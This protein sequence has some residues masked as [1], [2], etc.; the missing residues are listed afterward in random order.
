MM[1]VSWILQ[2]I[3]Y[4]KFSQLSDTPKSAEYPMSVIY[5]FLCT[6]PEEYGQSLDD[7][8]HITVM[9]F[10]THTFTGKLIADTYP[11]LYDTGRGEQ[12]LW[13]LIK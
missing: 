1:E 6:P 5:D 13:G 12:L 4:L 9:E 10:P 2:F 7:D 8:L 11:R 3:I